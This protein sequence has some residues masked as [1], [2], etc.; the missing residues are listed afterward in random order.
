MVKHNLKR[1]IGPAAKRAINLVGRFFYL[2]LVSVPILTF[3]AVGLVNR[4]V[5]RWR[6]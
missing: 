2:A 6:R 4:L 5:G 1:L 3:M